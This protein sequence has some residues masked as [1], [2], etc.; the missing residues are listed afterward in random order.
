MSHN[1]RIIEMTHRVGI[2]E[3]L[4]DLIVEL[5]REDLTTSYSCQ[6]DLMQEGYISFLDHLTEE[7]KKKA[8]KICSKHLP[9]EVC[10]FDP[11]R[12]GAHSSRLTICNSQEQVYRF[13]EKNQR[14]PQ[15]KER[16]IKYV[17][18]HSYSNGFYERT[19]ATFSSLSKRFGPKI[20]YSFG[21]EAKSIRQLV[22]CLNRF[23]AMEKSIPKSRAY[24]YVKAES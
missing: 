6:G 8:L 11:E 24:S 16:K 23:D 5:N 18:T 22:S 14:K 13:H 20:R 4:V 12:I 2:D 15:K 9:N 19:T 21:K 10:L 1:V 7:Q 3:K 17:L